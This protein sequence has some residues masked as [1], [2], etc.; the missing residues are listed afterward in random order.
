VDQPEENE[1]VERH[2]GLVGRT[3]L[4]SGLTLVSRLL[5][6]VREVVMAS[7]FGDTSAVSDAFFTA[8]RVPN[9]FRRLFGEGA[10]STSL[11]ASITEA[12]AEGGDEAGRRLFLATLKTG[13]WILLGVSLVSMLFIARLPDTM[14]LTGWAWMGTD[15][16]P[17][18]DLAVRLVPYVLLV[19]LAALAGGALYVRGHYFVPSVAP[20]VMNLA[21]IG[22]LVWIGSVFGWSES[23]EGSRQVV[24]ERQWDMARLLAWGVLG[25]GLLQLLLHVPPLVRFG[26]LWKQGEVRPT[27]KQLPGAWD[28]VRGAAPLALGAA[29]YQINVMVD[30]LMA[31][32]MLS[33]GGPTALYYANRVQQFPLALVATAAIA[34]VF[35]ALKAHGHL[36]ELGPL[37]RLHDHA[38]LGVLFLALPATAGLVGLAEPIASVLFGHGNY[39]ADG[40]G[41]VSEALA[42][43][44]LALV[45]AGAVGLLGRTYIALG[46]AKTPVRV[47]LWMVSVNVVLNVLF[48]RV[49]A[50]DVAGLALAT[51]A[52]SWGNLVLLGRGLHTKLGL[53]RGEGGLR[54]RVANTFLAAAVT[55]AA[56]RT[57]W[58]VASSLPG[59][60]ALAAAMTAGALAFAASASFLRLEE[61]AE[62]RRRIAGRLG[63]D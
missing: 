3:A 61:W 60:I 25:A 7:V 56:A 14:P 46:D 43:L 59:P 35:P 5:G 22:A 57:T 12:D 63:R 55:G 33:D 24:F 45:P 44:A 20:A 21:W 58:A 52:T 6:F 18:R 23:A 11:Q 2:R 48:V 47:S 62:L 34:S 16:G 30:G 49:F 9:L 53:P 10:L 41:R 4:V 8:W 1:I 54:A 50:M 37:R 42:V 36:G 39:G 26:L 40:V 38:Q 31:E 28:V 29:V 13:L 15:P 32:G 19:C 51:V 27:Q 17:V